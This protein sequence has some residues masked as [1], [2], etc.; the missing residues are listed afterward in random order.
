MGM[1]C[2]TALVIAILSWQSPVLGAGNPICVRPVGTEFDALK[3]ILD[4]SNDLLISAQV[5]A[6]NALFRYDFENGKL[7]KLANAQLDVE[8]WSQD[9]PDGQIFGTTDGLFHYDVRNHGVSKISDVRI[10]KSTEVRRV[11]GGLLINANYSLYLYTFATARLELVGSANLAEGWHDIP[12]GML[13]RSTSKGISRYDNST[14]AIVTVSR[15]LEARDW[16]DVPGGVLIKADE[17]LFRFD[18]NDGHIAMVDNSIKVNDWYDL[19]DGVLIRAYDPGGLYRLEFASGRITKLSDESPDIWSQSSLQKVPDGVLIRTDRGLFRYDVGSSTLNKLREV[20]GRNFFIPFWHQVPGGL[21]TTSGEHDLL[22]Y[23]FA[24]RQLEK[25]GSVPLDSADPEWFDVPDGAFFRDSSGT[26]LFDSKNS[27]VSRLGYPARVT[28]PFT[29]DVPGGVLI[30]TN[31]G[32]LRY[33]LASHKLAPVSSATG[34]TIVTGAIDGWLEV[35]NGLLVSGESG[36]WRYDDSSAKLVRLG[37]FSTGSY[38]RW[39]KVPG[40]ILIQAD[41]GW[42]SYD[43]AVGSLSEVSNI[44]VGEIIEWHDVPGDVLI[45]AE[46]GWFHFDRESGRLIRLVENLTGKVLERYSLPG[47]EV[48]LTENDW[49][50]YDLVNGR[51]EKVGGVPDIR[52]I[53][54]WHKV[55]SHV[56]AWGQGDLAY[57][58]RLLEIVDTP[59]S[60]RGSLRLLNAPDLQHS[61]S[62]PRREFTFRFAFEHKCAVVAEQLGFVATATRGVGEEKY[63]VPV[64]LFDHS[65]GRATFSVALPIPKSG[66]W[67]VGI[68]STVSGGD[69]MVG[70]PAELEFLSPASA[71]LGAWEKWL[72][73]ALGGL[74]TLLN[75]IF[76][77]SARWSGAAW[78]IATDSSWG[79]AV[80]RLPVIVLRHW[81]PAQLWILDLYFQKRR[82]A[83]PADR[84]PFL[85]FVLRS[86]GGREQ[87]SDRL[88]AS[89]GVGVRS[90]IQGS[91]GMGKSALVRR[92]SDGHF[93]D[94]PTAFAAYRRDGYVLVSIAARR[95]ADAAAEDK[96]DSAWLMACIRAILSSEGL[97]FESDALLRAILRKGTIAVVVDGLNEVGRGRSVEA[98]VDEY[99]DCP[100]VVTSQDEGDSRFQTWH[101]PV[102]IGEYLEKLLKLYLGEKAGKIVLGRLHACGLSA[103]L[104]SGYDMRLVVDLTVGDPDGATLPSD[105]LSLYRRVVDAAWPECGLE[106]R[107]LQQSQLEAAA[108]KLVSEREPYEDK[109]RLKPDVDLPR[110]LLIGLADAA[111]KSGRNVRLVRSVGLDFEFVH[112]Q[113]NAFLAA[114]W[115]AGHDRLVSEMKQMLSTSKVWKDTKEAQRDLWAFAAGMLNEAMIQDMWTEIRDYEPWDS[116]RRALENVADRQDLELKRVRKRP[117]SDPAN[118]NKRGGAIPTRSD[119]D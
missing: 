12:G 31:Q 46:L 54:Q 5:G 19:P 3:G 106:Q 87:E 16:H 2:R 51:F 47:N 95:F 1:A 84:A 58:D 8:V 74:L 43:T 6:N 37:N 27:A 70:E 113:M 28:G 64:R 60:Q 99:P 92:F 88:L 76:F 67:T 82:A 59:L 101:L 93:R 34:A 68:A 104:H 61:T 35:P 90:W 18:L 50:N 29:H 77:L 44:D 85:P 100:V 53:V 26:Y 94:V 39:Q 23:R 17:G 32:L 4:E 111:E 38:T 22:L 25:V 86:S 41:H 115:F 66:K 57:R 72:A 40:G 107:R 45:Q 97:T 13:L 98:F 63:R 102:D 20:K 7:V 65:D 14:G 42:F 69:V 49:F 10:Y 118:M 108:W 9:V 79:T 80:V 33:E 114:Q 24:S 78:R 30:N 62:D 11:S 36:I 71:G 55:G 48:F 89:F 52:R 116:L 96:R 109:R 112:D 117:R 75:A 91:S 56:L 83:L 73:G 110:S 119:L 15:D 105:R 81:R 21:L 103:S